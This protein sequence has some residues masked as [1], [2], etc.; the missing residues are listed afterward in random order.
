[1]SINGEGKNIK[2]GELMQNRGA[3]QP[4]Q[5]LTPQCLSKQ[6]MPKVPRAFVNHAN[7]KLVLLHTAEDFGFEEQQA[8]YFYSLLDAPISEIA[9]KTGLSQ[10]HVTCVLKL[11]SERLASKLDLFKRAVPYDANDLLP[12]SEILP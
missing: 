8:I 2:R 11:Y 9:D 4:Q 10:N 5:G 12:V 3:G 7:I 1:M 6:E